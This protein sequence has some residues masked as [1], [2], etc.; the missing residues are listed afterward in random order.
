MQKSSFSKT[1]GDV[2]NFNGIFHINNKI[3]DDWMSLANYQCVKS[4][5]LEDLSFAIG[6][7]LIRFPSMATKAFPRSQTLE[8]ASLLLRVPLLCHSLS[9]YK[10]NYERL[11]TPTSWSVSS[12]YKKFSPGA[13]YH[14]I[15]TNRTFFYFEKRIIGLPNSHIIILIKVNSK[16]TFFK[17]QWSKLAS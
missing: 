1:A 10:N 12:K 14:E 3:S 2:F 17:S 4:N 5:M 9:C 11:K 8:H 7:L 16:N 15:C 6:R 13:T